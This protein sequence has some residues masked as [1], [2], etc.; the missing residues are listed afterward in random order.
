MKERGNSVKKDRTYDAEGYT[1]RAGCL[2][3]KT[4]SERE[5]CNDP[6][7]RKLSAYQTYHL[8]SLSAGYVVLFLFRP[9]PLNPR[10]ERK[11][12]N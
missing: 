2:Y 7:S 6:F 8:V 1:R 4:N 11:Y 3:F 10:L 5:V 12:F 9:F